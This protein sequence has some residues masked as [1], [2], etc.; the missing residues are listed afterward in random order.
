[1]AAIAQYQSWLRPTIAAHP[2]AYPGLLDWL[3]AQ[4]GPA[5]TTALNA[6]RAATASAPDPAAAQ[7]GSTAPTPSAYPVTPPRKRARWWIW[8]LAG[9]LVVALAAARLP[10]WNT[11]TVNN[12][13]TCN[14][15]ITGTITSLGSELA[16]DQNGI[17]TAGAYPDGDY[18]AVIARY[19]ADGTRQW[20]AT[21]QG[22]DE[23]TG[24]FGVAAVGDGG[25]IATGSSFDGIGAVDSVGVIVRYDA[26]GTKKW[27]AAYQAPYA[28]TDFRSVAAVGDGG[29]I[30]A[31][32]SGSSGSPRTLGVV[33]R[34]SADGTKQWEATYN[35]PDPLTYFFGV[36]AVGDGG[37]IA[38]GNSR[39]YGDDDNS[40]GVIVRY[41][42]DGT[43]KWEATYQ[44]PKKYT[45]FKSVAAVGDGGAIAVGSSYG[46]DDSVGVVVRY[47]ADGTQQWKA[48]YRAP[49]T[50]TP[51]Y[52][53]SAT[54]DGGAIAT[55]E[56]GKLV[57]YTAD[58]KQA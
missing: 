26:D 55:T 36:A 1:L 38:A 10:I 2:N 51:F 27:E 47:N 53:V 32:Y 12:A 21:Y 50:D 37:A 7:A 52:S 3:A 54:A 39:S 4:N 49:N 13:S 34:Y 45:E 9:V 29:A 56:P 44:G 8:A 17:T 58:G 5:T 14:S 46:G 23:D 48:T 16:C 31:G 30:A 6:R 41:N 11:P 22:P 15:T 42:A 28:N 20:V 19:S 40:V 18:V 43:K 35:G 24:F 33:V 57:R 25:A